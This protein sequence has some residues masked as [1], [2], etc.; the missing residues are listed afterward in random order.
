MKG[1]KEIPEGGNIIIPGSSMDYKTGLWKDKYPVRNI[2]KCT[3][4][5]ICFS[6]CPENCIKVVKG[7]IQ[8]A[9][10]KYCKGCGI[11]AKECPF[12]AIHMEAGCFIK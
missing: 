1:Y 11:C 12:K 10:L 3:N 6:F 7:K 2:K 8:D 5:L 9:D 4:C